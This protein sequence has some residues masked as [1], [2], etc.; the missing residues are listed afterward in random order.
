MI[1]NKTFQFQMIPF[2][3]LSEFESRSIGTHL[4]FSISLQKYSSNDQI[5]SP[6]CLILEESYAC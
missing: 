6:D 1:Y 3:Q 5:M 2:Q 4:L